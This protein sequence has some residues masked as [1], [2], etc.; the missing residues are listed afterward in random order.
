M[1]ITSGETIPA[2]WEFLGGGVMIV[3]IPQVN[4]TY[5]ASWSFAGDRMNIVTELDPENPTYR[6]IEFVSN[7][8]FIA[9]KESFSE[10]WSRTE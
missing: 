5:G 3:S 10:T 1:T 9:S 7:D 4:I 2:T 8:V 6:D